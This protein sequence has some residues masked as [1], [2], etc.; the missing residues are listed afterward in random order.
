[1]LECLLALLVA[2][3]LFGLLVIGFRIGSRPSR[4]RLD[5]HAGFLEY[6]RGEDR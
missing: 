2:G 5:P 4:P 1:M 3:S 6:H